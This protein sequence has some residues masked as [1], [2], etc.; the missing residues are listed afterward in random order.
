MRRLCSSAAA[1]SHCDAAP[2]STFRIAPDC[3]RRARA[4]WA[5]GHHGRSGARE[6]SFHLSQGKPS[7][8][9]PNDESQDWN[10]AVERPKL[11]LLVRAQ[12]RDYL[13]VPTSTE[14]KSAAIAG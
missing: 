1:E 7:L 14:P 11:G 6:R 9:P 12:R 5:N 3:R 13:G 8:P 2:A 10:L 4:P